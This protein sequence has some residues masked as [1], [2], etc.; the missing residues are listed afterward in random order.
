MDAEPGFV[1]GAAID[2]MRREQR[3]KPIVAA[4]IERA[5]R[6]P[7]QHHIARRIGQHGLVDAIATVGGDIGEGKGGHAVLDRTHG[8]ARVA[9]LFREIIAAVGDDE[10]E[11]ACASVVDARIINLIEDAVADRVPDAALRRERRADRTFGAGCPARRNARPTGSLAAHTLHPLVARGRMK[12]STAAAKPSS[13]LVKVV[14]RASRFTASFALPIAMLKP[15]WWNI[16]TSFSI[17]P[18]V[19]IAVSG[20]PIV[21]ASSRTARPLSI[22]GA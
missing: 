13:S 2:E 20:T 11:I 17:S 15:V 9:F 8:T 14:S 6:N 4:A 5:K 16:G 10:A 19:T 1:I 22:P 3:E 18:S 12:R 7:L 21:S